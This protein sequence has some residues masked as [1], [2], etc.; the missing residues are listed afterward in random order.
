M[1]HQTIYIVT[2]TSIVSQIDSKRYNIKLYWKMVNQ[3]FKSWE[4]F[5]E[6]C[7]KCLSYFSCSCSKYCLYFIITVFLIGKWR[8]CSVL[9]YFSFCF[10]KTS[11]SKI[12]NISWLILSEYHNDFVMFCRILCHF[13]LRRDFWEFQ[14]DACSLLQR[15]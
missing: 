6:K 12:K 10:V 15:S 4:I 11:D 13:N 5:N 9:E 8:F 2:S 14:A 1:V 7:D 3:T